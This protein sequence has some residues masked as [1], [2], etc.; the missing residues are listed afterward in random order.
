MAALGDVLVAQAELAT[1]QDPQGAAQLLEA[2]L[3]DGYGAALCVNS[4]CPEGLVGA[5]EAQCALGSL[6]LNG[7]V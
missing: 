2:A 4:L 7:R 5:A 1:P 3:R 6:A